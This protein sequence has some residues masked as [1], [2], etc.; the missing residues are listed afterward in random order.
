[1]SV[2]FSWEPKMPG[3]RVHYSLPP[4]FHS[5]IIGRPSLL[6]HQFYSP[7]YPFA[8]RIVIALHLLFASYLHNLQISVLL[9]PMSLIIIVAVIA[10]ALPAPS[11][12][13]GTSVPGQVSSSA[14]TARLHDQLIK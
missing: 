4:P 14:P 2:E 5:P 6:L 13:E 3:H 12:G 1:M 8:S 7:H 10:V 9:V 11:L